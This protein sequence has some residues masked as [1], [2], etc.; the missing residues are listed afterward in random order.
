MFVY[1]SLFMCLF[2]Y[3]YICL[4]VFLS[5]LFIVFFQIVCVFIRPCLFFSLY[6]SSFLYPCVYLFVS[7]PVIFT[8]LSY[9]ILLCSPL[10]T[11]APFLLVSYRSFSCSTEALPPP[12]RPSRSR[13]GR[14]VRVG[15][16]EH[17]GRE[18]RAL[19][20]IPVQP[21]FL[22]LR[23][24]SLH[25]DDSDQHGGPLWRHIRHLRA[26]AGCFSGTGSPELRRCV[27]CVRGLSGG[28]SAAAVFVGARLASCALSRYVFCSAAYVA[29][30][31]R[32]DSFGSRTGA[33]KSFRGGGG[34]GRYIPPLPLRNFFLAPV[35][36]PNES[37]LKRTGTP[38]TQAI[39]SV[40]ARLPN[41]R[42]KIKPQYCAHCCTV[43]PLSAVD[44]PTHCACLI[45]Q[46]IHGR[47]LSTQTSLTGCTSRTSTNRPTKTCYSVSCVRSLKVCWY[48]PKTLQD[49]Q[50]DRQEVT[51]PCS[52]LVNRQL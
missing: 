39:F 37:C 49:W 46:P 10:S 43:R 44:Q 20:Q 47:Q 12:R 32:Q 18:P 7:S 28:S 9:C 24:G 29:G 36:L 40:L 23:L 26:V 31:F 19:H 5:V 8:L 52:W 30:I 48:S 27:A 15:R 35:L 14:L 4:F 33:R 34:G 45:L 16:Q 42:D 17:G 11:Y 50:V 3:L 1:S 51:V 22:P 6:V 13:A 2:T 21:V 41:F 38:A 25:D